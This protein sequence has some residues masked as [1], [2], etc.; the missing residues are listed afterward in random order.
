MRTM[1]QF[2][3]IHR[4]RYMHMKNNK[5]YPNNLELAEIFQDFTF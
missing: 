1:N 5:S 2:E 4:V 3:R